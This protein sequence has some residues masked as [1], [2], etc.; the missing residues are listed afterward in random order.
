MPAPDEQR[1]DVDRLYA[2]LESVEPP[3][4]FVARVMA[5]ARQSDAVRWPR[6]QQAGFG[7]LYV[8]AL[9]ALAVLAYLM[10]RELE[11]AGLRDL[12]SLAVHDLTLVTDSPGVY[13]AALRDAIPWLHLL[14]VTLDVLL[15]AISTR[16]VL[17]VTRPFTGT[18]TGVLS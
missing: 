13:L 8:V 1:D 15:L 9:A 16:L 14:A 3:A 11:H 4:D 17:R 10:G 2:H 12:L 7:V 5:R 18:S 6:W